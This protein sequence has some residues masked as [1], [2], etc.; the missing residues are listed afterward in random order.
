MKASKIFFQAGLSSAW[1]V[2]CLRNHHPSA[3]PDPGILYAQVQ[4]RPKC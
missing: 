3:V 1:V 2:A 4:G